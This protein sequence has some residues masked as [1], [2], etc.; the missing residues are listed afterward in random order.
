[1]INELRKLTLT[2][3]PDLINEPAVRLIMQRFVEHE[4]LATFEWWRTPD[5]DK[6]TAGRLITS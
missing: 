6:R 5:F 2:G 3:N 1:M 4:G